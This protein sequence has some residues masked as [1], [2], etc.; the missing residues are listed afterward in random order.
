MSTIQ[1]LAKTAKTYN[2]DYS[3]VVTHHA[4]NSPV[5]GLTCGEQTGS[6]IPLYLWLYVKEW[7]I[8]QTMYSSI[9]PSFIPQVEYDDELG[10][11][12]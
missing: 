4:T 10:P 8:F 9:S 5:K 6:G 7:A 1:T 2:S 12:P 11:L 3:R